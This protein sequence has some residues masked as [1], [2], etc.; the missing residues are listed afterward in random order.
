MGG[1]MSDTTMTEAEADAM[2]DAPQSASAIAIA[3]LEACVKMRSDD[4]RN[5]GLMPANE[6]LCELLESLGYGDV[7]AAWREVPK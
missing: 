6:V 1:V 3:K 4:G 7:V 2:A 5:Q